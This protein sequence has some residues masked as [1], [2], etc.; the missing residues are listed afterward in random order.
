MA[1]FVT[2]AEEG[3]QIWDFNVEHGGEVF[4]NGLIRLGHLVLK[5]VAVVVGAKTALTGAGV[6]L[7]G[8]GVKSVGVGM[9]AVGAK[10][11]SSGLVAKGLGHRLI[12]KNLPPF[13]K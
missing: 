3:K 4:K 1:K 12:A 7:F 2:A 11:V 10:M 5:P 13:L 6:G 8:T 9:E